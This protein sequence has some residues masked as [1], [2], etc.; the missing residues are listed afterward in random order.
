[1]AI[2]GMIKM[3]MHCSNGREEGSVA[4]RLGGVQM[5]DT[6]NKNFSLLTQAEVDTLIDFL[7]EQRDGAVE[8]SVLNQTSIDRL[9]ELLRLNEIRRKR[10]A[11]KS[12]SEVAGALAGLI[13]VRQG[14]EL[15]ELTVSVDEAEDCVKLIVVNR[16]DGRQME[17]MPEL[18]N[19]G[20]GDSWGRC[21]PPIIVSK[22]ARVL[23]VKYTTQTYEAVCERY[24][25]CLFGDASHKL[26]YTYL[27]DNAETIENLI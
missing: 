19:E 3:V 18:L 26:P 1:M 27:P 11:L 21:V 20:D 25:Q 7:T 13:S 23:G 16:E 9:I 12:V 2:Y 24:A 6:Q 22:L 15:C 8:S 4:V 10:D 5:S 14:E 17:I